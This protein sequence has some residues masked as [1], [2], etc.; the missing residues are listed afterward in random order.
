MPVVGAA[1]LPTKNRGLMGD[2]KSEL[3][4]FL[5]RMSPPGNVVLDKGI[6]SDR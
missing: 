3:V 1:W 6:L 2:K 4:S 5:S